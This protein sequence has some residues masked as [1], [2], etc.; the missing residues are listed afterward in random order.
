M[1][2]RTIPRVMRM[3]PLDKEGRYTEFAY[4]EVEFDIELADNVFTQQNLKNP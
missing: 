4:V 1:Y 3:V 2:D